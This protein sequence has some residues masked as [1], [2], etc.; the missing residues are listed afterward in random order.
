MP[1]L[2]CQYRQHKR[3][4]IENEHLLAIAL[5]GMVIDPTPKIR[6]QRAFKSFSL[7]D[8]LAPTREGNPTFSWTIDQP[9]CSFCV[10]EGRREPRAVQRH[11][12]HGYFVNPSAV[13]R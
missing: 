1:P 11:L 5:M 3:A 12:S 6:R 7:S 13:H 4:A 9:T 8:D 2:A 10:C